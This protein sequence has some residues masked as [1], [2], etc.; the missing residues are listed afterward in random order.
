M[1]AEVSITYTTT[2]TEDGMT[3]EEFRDYIEAKLFR[4]LDI[5][6]GYA[7]EESCEINIEEQWW[8][9][10]DLYGEDEEE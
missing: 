9:D 7:D 5:G 2:I 6:I 8:E 10:K 4:S 1:E 3:E